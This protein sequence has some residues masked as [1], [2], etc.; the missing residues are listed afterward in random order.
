VRIGCGGDAVIRT[1]SGSAHDGHILLGMRDRGRTSEPIRAASGSR[2][3]ARTIEEL[4]FEA[5]RARFGSLLDNAD[6]ARDGN[7][8][9]AIHD[10]RV[11]TRRIRTL[12]LI[13]R[14]DLPLSA[15]PFRAEF[16]WLGRTLGGLRD[17]DVAILRLSE[18]PAQ[19]GAEL[20]ASVLAPV[21]SVLEDDR[22]E[23]LER[24]REAVDSDRY[25]RLV[26]GFSDFLAEGPRG[27]AGT[28]VP[29]AARKILGRL[30]S[31][32]LKSGRALRSSSPPEDFHRFRIRCKRLRY[33]TEAV[34]DLYGEPASNAIRRLVKIQDGLGSHQDA[35]MGIARLRSMAEHP[36][37]QLSAG[38]I[39]AM[40]E[41]AGC[42][43]ME[44]D[45]IRASVPR[46][47]R[48]LRRALEE[49]DQRMERVERDSPDIGREPPPTQALRSVGPSM[50]TPGRGRSAG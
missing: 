29:V 45:R 50:S 1:K 19:P 3:G 4:A 28:P 36:A 48:K 41:V 22:R 14:E 21:I 42:Y 13:F 17:L 40:G 20:D 34:G 11:A 8:P 31:R 47:V 46:S 6:S 9:E 24:L 39:F 12:S 18:L 23:A 26:S 7:D 38:T 32:A 5:L 35:Q 25:E 16:G 10:M 44:A 37:L 2:P 27:S 30:S 33:A 49:F 43:A 15:R